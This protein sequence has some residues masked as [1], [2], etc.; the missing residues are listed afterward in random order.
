MEKLE[1][2]ASQIDAL[3][4]DIK[5]EVIINDLLKNHKID[6]N[7]YVTQHEGQF[8]RAYR[9]DILESEILDHEYN[10][11]QTFPGQFLW[12]ASGKPDPWY[13]EWRS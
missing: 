1:Y 7:Q 4:Y 10:D 11:Q 6:E 5:A 8:S 2:I 3:K 9:F 13:Q 12:Y